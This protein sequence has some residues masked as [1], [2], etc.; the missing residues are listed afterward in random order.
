MVT[1][2]ILSGSQAGGIAEQ[3]QVEAEINVSTGYAEYVEAVNGQWTK[4]DRPGAQPAAA[5]APAPS[6]DPKAPKAPKPPKGGKK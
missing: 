4:V 2:R 1:V 6:T 5:A 3:S